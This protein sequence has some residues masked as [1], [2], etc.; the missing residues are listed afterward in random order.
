MNIVQNKT[1]QNIETNV[2]MVHC[3]LHTL[4]SLIYK[5]DNCPNGSSFLPHHKNVMFACLCAQVFSAASLL[6]ETPALRIVGMTK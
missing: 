3:I 2:E 4:I 1:I 6:S 5:V